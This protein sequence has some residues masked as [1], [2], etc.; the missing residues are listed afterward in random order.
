MLSAKESEEQLHALGKGE[1]LGV[2]TR[3]LR[4]RRLHL[5]GRGLRLR[6]LAC[7]TA[8]AAFGTGGGFLRLDELAVLV[9]KLVD[10]LFDFQ[11]EH[12]AYAA[13]DDGNGADDAHRDILLSHERAADG[14][15]DD[16]HD[17][18]SKADDEPDGRHDVRPLLR[19]GRDDVGHGLIH[20]VGERRNGDDGHA[21][22]ICIDDAVHLGVILRRPHGHHG[23]EREQRQTEEDVRLISAPLGALLFH[24]LPDE[25]DEEHVDKRTAYVDGVAVD[26]IDAVEIGDVSDGDDQHD[27]VVD[28]AVAQRIHPE[29]QDLFEIEEPAFQRLIPHGFHR[30]EQLGDFLFHISLPFEV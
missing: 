8:L 21:G 15:H 28:P 19:V 10:A 26:G 14:T 23:E 2:R 1:L 3:G 5:G 9:L 17:G 6:D 7:Y 30:G 22:T 20:I 11:D 13:D 18:G 12:H 27:R 4:L 16:V 29:G 25:G 24:R